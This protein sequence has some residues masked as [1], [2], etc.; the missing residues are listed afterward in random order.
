V[1]DGIF[2]DIYRLFHGVL[3]ARE[4]TII[5]AVSLDH[6]SSVSERDVISY[7]HHGT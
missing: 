1:T 7:A 6:P 2:G 3:A 5:L 4:R